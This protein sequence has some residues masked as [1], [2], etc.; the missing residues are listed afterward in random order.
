MA[1]FRA[2]DWRSI[3]GEPL[4]EQR[5]AF[6]RQVIEAELLLDKIRQRIGVSEAEFDAA[7]E[8]DSHDGDADDLYRLARCVELLGGSLE[9]RAVFAGRSIALLGPALRTAGS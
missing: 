8:P 5:V 6:Y 9:V 1:N 3:R 7:L 2:E 4:D